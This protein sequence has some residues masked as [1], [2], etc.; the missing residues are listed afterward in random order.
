[1][2]MLQAVRRRS[3]PSLAKLVWLSLFVE[4]PH[5]VPCQAANAQQGRTKM[6]V[7]KGRAGAS[8]AVTLL[9]AAATLCW[10]Y[11]QTGHAQTASDGFF[12]LVRAG[13]AAAVEKLVTS[14]AD[15]NARDATGQ[16][17][18]IT[19]ALARQDSVAEFL[20]NHG[21]NL[22]ART[23]KGMTAL[24]AAAYSG[25]L[26]IAQMLVKHGADIND[27]SNIAGI[28]PLHAAAEEDRL[29][30]AE[31]LVKSGADVT[32]AEVNGYTAGSRAGWR[33]HWD[34]VKLLLRAGDKCQPE[35]LAGPWLYGKCTHL[36]P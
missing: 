1:M 9:L 17:P 31:A 32:L 27:R 30:V 16:T 3:A 19:A 12:E 14:G 34:I 29:D 24:H 23:D 21:A 11:L 33:E 2:T 25:D 5:T 13:D 28:T 4:I 36:T 10:P 26:V 8:S 6:K 7:I 20:V 22:M 35:A 15:V 18:L